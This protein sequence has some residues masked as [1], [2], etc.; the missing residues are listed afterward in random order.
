MNELID[1]IEEQTRELS[2]EG[3]VLHV[4]RRFGDRVALSSSLGAEDQV[5][6][7]MVCR[8]TPRF[9]IFTLDTGRIPEETYDVIAATN[10]RYGIRITVLFPDREEVESMVNKEGPNLFYRSVEARRLCCRVR[11]VL[12]LRR[13]L[14][15]LGCWMTG[16]RRKQST[17]R[18]ALRRVEWDEANGLVKANPLVDWTTKQVWDYIREHKVPYNRL[19]DLGYPSIGCA[20]CTRAVSAGEDLRSGR[21]WWELPDHKECGLH[22]AYGRAV[23]KSR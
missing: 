21:W 14:K 4:A 19:H 2:A 6:T 20:P 5:L 1:E 10:E 9:R 11:K 8:L 17:T 13:Q 16:L 15:E 22:V 3:F 23:G 7:D 18:T 12:P